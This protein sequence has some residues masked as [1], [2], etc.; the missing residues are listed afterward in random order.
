M[1]AEDIRRAAKLHESLLLLV[2]LIDRAKK[3]GQDATTIFDVDGWKI[4][5]ESGT[6][7]AMFS[8][9]EKL[10]QAQLVELGVEGFIGW[11]DP[12][13]DEV[14]EALQP[15]AQRLAPVKPNATQSEFG[16]AE[17]VIFDALQRDQDGDPYM[18]FD[19]QRMRSI[20]IRMA[21]E[22]ADWLKLPGSIPSPSI[23]DVEH[24]VLAVVGQTSSGRERCAQILARLQDIGALRFGPPRTA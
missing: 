6:A 15:S 11:H 2:G 5:F 13:F 1:K 8:T 9:A 19:D 12:D 4:G 20:R 10:L 22:R 7:R 21:L 24:S 3:F 14:N 17:D 16:V 18:S 23:G